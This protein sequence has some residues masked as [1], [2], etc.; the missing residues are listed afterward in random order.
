MLGE[1]FYKEIGG[2][3]T[4]TFFSKNTTLDIQ[5]MLPT[6]IRQMRF[7]ETVRKI[8]MLR[9]KQ[10]QSTE[11]INTLFDALMQKAFRGEL[12]DAQL[13]LPI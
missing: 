1:R 7:A 11:E 13:E 2:T 12:G 10:K 8:K 9:Q 4:L 6:I 3:S 5:I